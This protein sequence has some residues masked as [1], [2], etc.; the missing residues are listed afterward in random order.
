M[1]NIHSTKTVS[2]LVVCL[3][4]DDCD[5]SV[6][7]I[8]LKWRWI[9][10]TDCIDYSIFAFLILSCILSF[11]FV[12]F[13]CSRHSVRMSCWNKRLLTFLLTCIDN[14]QGS[15][16]K[17]G[18][19][20]I[21]TVVNEFSKHDDDDEGKEEWSESHDDDDDTTSVSNVSGE[22]PRLRVSQIAAASRQYSGIKP[23]FT[24]RVV[25][26]VYQFFVVFN[27]AE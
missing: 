3:T 27:I 21:P 12:C 26:G 18:K 8:M 22:S 23:Y 20:L 9:R 10:L 25:F 17:N 4:F 24:W 6:V 7:V 13:N 14:A 2:S 19:Q 1:L 5:M 11:F 16:S 15:K